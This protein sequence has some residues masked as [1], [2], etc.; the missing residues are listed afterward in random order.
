VKPKRSCA[1][2]ISPAPLV[3][4]PAVNTVVP[5][6][7][8]NAHDPAILATPLRSRSPCKDAVPIAFVSPPVG[9]TP[10][11]ARADAVAPGPLT[12]YSQSG[13]Q[14][15]QIGRISSPSMAPNTYLAGAGKRKGDDAVLTTS[16][17]R[18]ATLDLVAGNC[19]MD[20]SDQVSTKNLVVHLMLLF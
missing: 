15:M 6:L 1:T 8:G 13:M 19:S 7:K 17:K 16:S 20:S 12:G 11:D 18:Q 9:S 14:V 3:M 2:P 4:V 5:P 10:A